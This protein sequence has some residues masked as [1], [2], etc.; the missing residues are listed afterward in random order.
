MD[1]RDDLFLVRN[2]DGV[3]S[4]RELLRWEFARHGR[5]LRVIILSRVQIQVQVQLQVQVQ[6]YVQLLAQQGIDCGA[7]LL[8]LILGTIHVFFF[9]ASESF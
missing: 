3:E 7:F 5:R 4:V 6:V 8:D 2:D 1:V 9:Q